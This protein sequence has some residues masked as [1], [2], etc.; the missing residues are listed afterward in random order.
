MLERDSTGFEGPQRV[1]E[2]DQELLQFLDTAVLEDL[3][4]DL[5]VKL[6]SQLKER[7]S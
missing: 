4:T 2:N 1:P 7:R 6:A 5:L 3:P